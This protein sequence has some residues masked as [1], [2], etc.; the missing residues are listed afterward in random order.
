MKCLVCGSEKIICRKTRISKFLIAR[1][2]DK[3]VP[4]EE[5]NVNLCHCETCSFSFYDRRLTDEEEGKLYINYRTS[6]YQ[7]Q[8][9]QYD[10]W[11]T[12][13]VNEAL[14]NDEMALEEQRRVISKMIRDNIDQT[15]NN[16]LDYGGNRGDTF[17]K[18]MNIRNK[19]VY[20]ISDVDV[21]DGVNK[22]SSYE[23]LK[24][25]TFDFIMCNMVLEH[26]ASPVA[27]AK[28]LYDIGT[29]GTYYYFEVPSENPFQKNKFSIKKNLK[30][31]LN[32][33]F[34]KIKLVKH[35]LNIRKEPYMPMHEH[36]N[37]YTPKSIRTLME[38]AGF[39]V[40]SVEENYEKSVLGGTLVLSALCRK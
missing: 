13:K 4:P 1:A 9:E 24:K 7:K 39:E 15:I 18:D 11:Y 2:L 5:T 23:D 34:N 32:P 36:V 35:Y 25:I 17:G 3:N 40:I 31:L 38:N 14:N 22:I 30:L 12:A 21:I 26:I 10:C 33:N 19:Y 16:A 8:R 6:E 27:F 37:F 20:D 28:D 29:K